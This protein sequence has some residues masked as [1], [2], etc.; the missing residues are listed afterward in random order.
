[1]HLQ[2]CKLRGNQSIS[3]LIASSV[4]KTAYSGH[5]KYLQSKEPRNKQVRTDQQR[6][7]GQRGDSCPWGA[8]G[9]GD[10][11]TQLHVEKSVKVGHAQSP[12]SAPLTTSYRQVV[13]FRP[14]DKKN[15]WLR[16]W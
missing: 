9:E 10:Q 16:P 4:I 3:A 8:A 1:M 12:A 14:F 13:C 11:S 15:S 7:W 5:S 2:S 6:N